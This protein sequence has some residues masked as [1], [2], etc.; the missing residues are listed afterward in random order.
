M[1]NF[2]SAQNM[3][4]NIKTE[5]ATFRL[6]NLT[7]HGSF[8]TEAHVAMRTHH[9][10]QFNLSFWASE[11]TE[12]GYGLHMVN[13]SCALPGNAVRFSLTIHRGRHCDNLDA[14]IDFSSLVIEG[15][16]WSIK[17]AGMPV[18]D[19]VDG[20]HHRLDVSISQR[21][22][23]DEWNVPPHG[24]VGQ[25]FDREPR[26]GRVGGYPRM[27]RED[28]YP[29]REV[30]ADF[31]TQA[32]AEGAIDGVASEYE[33]ASPFE[34]AFKYASYGG[35]TTAQK[36]AWQVGFAPDGARS[37][38]RR[39]RRRRRRQLRARAAAAADAL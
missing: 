32:M 7:V 8:I 36:R 29:P 3:S 15:D 30:H 17:V 31:T 18:Y 35:A 33:M 38:A 1:Y 21:V 11:L 4:M 13:G 34:T 25:S 23:E 20:P 6:G 14:Q 27:G 9:G 5:D 19:R 16:E 28:A 10:R 26:P 37:T 2:L 22:P 39:D 12:R 24:L